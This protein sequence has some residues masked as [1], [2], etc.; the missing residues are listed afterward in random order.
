MEQSIVHIALVVKDYDEAIDFYVNSLNFELIEDTYQP[1]Q[2]KRW[3]VVS[4]PGS[5]GVTLLLARASK[6]EQ[7]PFIGNQAG[8]RVFLF[9]RTDDFWRDYE[10]MRSKG[11]TFIRDPSEQ[12]YGTV[13]VF[14]DLYGNRWDLL[15]LNPE[16]PMAKR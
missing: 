3:V 10:R 1:E 4:P 16:H 12:D 2:D 14:E 9:L 7:E 5:K 11:I 8:G 6:E 13:A 15:Q